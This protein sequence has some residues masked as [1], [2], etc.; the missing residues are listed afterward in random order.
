MFDMLT[1]RELS[2]LHDSLF[3]SC[4]R[5]H[6]RMLAADGTALIPVF[7]DDWQILR[8]AHDDLHDMMDAVF[9]EIA[10]RDCEAVHA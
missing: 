1:R 5:I 7:S 4:T 6:Q 9:A 8:A 3:N 2:I 10:R